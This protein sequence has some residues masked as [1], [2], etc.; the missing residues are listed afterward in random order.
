MFKIESDSFNLVFE[1]ERR[2]TIL[3]GDSGKGKTEMVTLLQAFTGGANYVNVVLPDD[4][5]DIMIVNNTTWKTAI[6]LSKNSLIVFDDDQ[7]IENPDFYAVLKET[8]VQNNNYC[9]LIY[10]GDLDDGWRR[11]IDT[12]IPLSVDS[13]FD[14]NYLGSYEYEFVLS[15]PGCYNEAKKL[16]EF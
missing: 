8:L 16:P 4:I 11:D 2:I 14:M 12:K 10:R 13:I 6:P 1:M 5:T 15:Y 9:L 3:K 7:N